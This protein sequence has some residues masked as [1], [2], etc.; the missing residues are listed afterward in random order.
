MISGS[1]SS[2]YLKLPLRHAPTYVKIVIFNILHL[3]SRAWGRKRLRG[4]VE[5]FK[6]VLQVS[7]LNAEIQG[8]VARDNSL[9]CIQPSLAQKRSGVIISM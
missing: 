3:A 7:R 2:A 4:A 5:A 8:H 6:L 9:S 1:V